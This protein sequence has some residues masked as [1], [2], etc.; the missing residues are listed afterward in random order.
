MRAV[1]CVR[2]CG[3]GAFPLVRRQPRLLAQMIVSQMCGG[4]PAPTS[5]RGHAGLV[6][7]LGFDRL[8]PFNTLQLGVTLPKDSFYTQDELPSDLLE[9]LRWCTLGQQYNWTTKEY[10]LGSSPFDTDAD[11]LMR[12]IA[13]AITHPDE[14]SDMPASNGYDG[15]AFVSEA[16][17]VNYYDERATMAG[18]VDKT[19]EKMDAPLISFSIGLSC[20]YLI[21]SAIRDTEPTAL[22]LRSGDVLA[23]CGESRMAYHGVPRVFAGTSPEF[24]SCP[25]AGD[26]DKAAEM[27]PEWHYFARYLSRHRI[28]CN[29]R[30]CS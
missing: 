17:I 20:I 14:A 29:A 15:A 5:W 8:L 27:Y 23:M 11:A 4:G 30:K 6:D 24:L 22:M 26:Q 12:A 9:R 28:N 7:R 3:S 10:D 25:A 16:G 18:H 1:L 21:G 13:L 19:E 2:P